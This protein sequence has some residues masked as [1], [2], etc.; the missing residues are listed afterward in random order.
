MNYVGLAEALFIQAMVIEH[1]GG[2]HGITEQ[3]FEKLETALAA[4]QQSMFGVDLYPDL[5]TKAAAVFDALVNGH[6]FS[7]GNKR[8][9]LL[10][11][12][13][14]LTRNGIHFTAPDNDSL[15]NWI[16]AAAARTTTRI[17]Q[18]AWIAHHSEVE[19][20]RC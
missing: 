20:G 8:T 6:C 16:L 13:D 14:F 1:I 10:V 4:P 19:H 11:M 15:Y 9:A 12:I 17:E 3:G 18:A 5:Y 2:I 7:D